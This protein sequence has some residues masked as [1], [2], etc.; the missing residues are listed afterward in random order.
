MSSCATLKVAS[1]V[2]FMHKDE[3]SGYALQNPLTLRT[4]VCS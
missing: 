3:M 1:G 2:A 4:L